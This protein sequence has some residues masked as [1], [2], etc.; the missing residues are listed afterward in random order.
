MSLQHVSVSNNKILRG[1]EKDV[2]RRMKENSELMLEINQKKKNQILLR[3]MNEELKEEREILKKQLDQNYMTK[4]ESTRAQTSMTKR[5]AVSRD[6]FRSKEKSFVM[7]RHGSKEKEL[8][9]LQK[10]KSRID[11]S[12]KTLMYKDETREKNTKFFY[13]AR[14]LQSARNTIKVQ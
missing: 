8:K 13:I 5:R 3:Q 1:K 11:T 7:T 2:A 12:H 4:R 9:D 10:E 6:Q 14:Q